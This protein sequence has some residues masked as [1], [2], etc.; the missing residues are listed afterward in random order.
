M[1]KTNNKILLF[2][3]CG[4]F[5]ISAGFVLSA[6]LEVE[7]PASTSGIVL[8]DTSTP[9]PLFFKYIFEIGTFLGFVA[10]VYSL[11][12]AGVLYLMSPA[13]P[14]LL[15]SAKD[16]VFGAISGILILIMTY[17]IVTTINPQL[18]IFQI[19]ELEEVP[20]FVSEKSAGVYF[21]KSTDCSDEPIFATTNILDFK[22]K[23]NLINSVLIINKPDNAF[24]STIYGNP[25]LFG[26]CLYVNPNTTTCQTIDNLANSAS[27]RIYNF[28]NNS[29][30][31][32]TFFRKPFFNK[33]G[34]FLEIPDSFISDK[35]T[36]FMADLSTLTFADSSG[37]NVPISEQLCEKWNNNG[38]CIQK[39]CP[40]LAGKEI[41]SIKIEGNYIIKFVY[42][43]P[44]DPSKGPFTYCQEFP[45]PNDADKEGPKQIKW[46]KIYN[47]PNLANWIYIYPIKN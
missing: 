18:A 31:K 22:E 44:K 5:L 37:C 23:N 7:Y 1:K 21:Y 36:I 3:I 14:E 39:K 4:L 25:G 28:K 6:S 11:S 35:D 16:R 32:I 29:D 30:G 27:V 8:T 13:K 2:F 38:D 9:L 20:D 34:G 15:S 43:D 26:K 46:E 24:V 33:D 17:L 47:Q 40:T 41:S 45:T 12:Y 10:A 19:S 42:F